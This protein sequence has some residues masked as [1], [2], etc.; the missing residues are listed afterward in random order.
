MGGITVYTDEAPI[1]KNTTG[2]VVQTKEQVLRDVTSACIHCA[3]CVDACPVNLLPTRIA[4]YSDLGKYEECE[5]LYAMNCIE[6]GSCAMVCPSK[7]HLV[8]LI[9]YSKLQIQ[10]MCTAEARGGD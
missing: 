2:I 7:R 4:S 9:R 3:R 6:C 1:V 8:Q 10:N 5:H